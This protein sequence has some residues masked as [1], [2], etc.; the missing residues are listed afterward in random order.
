[1]RKKVEVI[2]MHRIVNYGSV[3]QAYATQQII[4]KL[5]YDIEF[6]D[7]YPERMHMMGMLKRIKNKKNI[8]KKS[9]FLR[10]IARIIILPSY[11]KRFFV[12]KNFI[13]DKLNLSEKTYYT[14]DD[15]NKKLP[16]AD[17]Y[18]TGSDQV[19]N[20]GWNE[21]I[22]KSFFLDFGCIDNT[23]KIAYAASFG[24]DKLNENEIDKTKELLKKYKYIS[25]REKSGVNILENLGIE[26]STNVVD[27]TLLLNKKNWE[28][29]TSDK[30]DN[31]DYILI[32][33]LNR[34]KKIDKY[35]KKIS[36]QTGLKIKRLSY[37]FHEFY[38]IG[39]SCFI[40]NVSDFL[41]LIKNSKY[42][43]TDSFHAIVFSVIFN[44]EFFILYPDKYST[45]LQSILEL[46]N[47]EDR[48]IYDITDLK[49][50]NKKINYKSVN[51]KI[52]VLK[53]ESIEWLK[54][55]LK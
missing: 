15:I 2:T 28:S 44:K 48:V 26:N 9:F 1:M 13:K 55:A 3:L 19:W 32:Y 4:K 53:K 23:K 34:N 35:S 39:N 8:F 21:K 30:Y 24:K 45:R 17:I 51:K 43:I 52:N 22:D 33:N 5:G 20:S 18:C 40:P 7:Y 10:N 29:I 12:F 54:D 49:I 50:L 6:I 27:P 31:K 42:I 38:K 47:L 41:S 37:Q 25:V 11:I 36:K 14:Y 16:I 46:L